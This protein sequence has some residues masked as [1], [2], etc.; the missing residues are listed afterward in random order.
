M[1]NT[2]E[3]KQLG[4]PVNANS[5]RQ[6]RIQQRLAKQEQ[7]LLKRG[8]PIVEGSQRQLKLKIKNEKINNGIEVKRGRPINVNSE[9]QIKL[10]KRNTEN[11]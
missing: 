8:R 1:T 4:R 7:G 6:Q 2:T 3:T 11:K 5:A 9:R 10:A